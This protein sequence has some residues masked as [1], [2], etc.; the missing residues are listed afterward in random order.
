ML[1]IRL[2][3]EALG[4]G[5]MLDGEVRVRSQELPRFLLLLFDPAKLRQ[6]GG[7]N[8]LRPGASRCLEP[9]RLNGRLVAA[10]LI[11]RSP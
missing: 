11:L 9:Q 1:S 10:R 4:G 7:E 2:L 6:G 3:S 5:P 8:T